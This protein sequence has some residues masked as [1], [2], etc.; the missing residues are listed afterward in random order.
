[1]RTGELISG[2]SVWTGWGFEANS[3]GALSLFVIVTLAPKPT[4]VV[5]GETPCA[6][7]VIEPPEAMVPP[8]VGS[9]GEDDLLHDARSAAS[10]RTPRIGVPFERTRIRFMDR[11]SAL[12]TSNEG[13]SR[14]VEGV[15]CSWSRDASFK[16]NAR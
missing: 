13:A 14:E 1:M 8:I 2:Q 11:T 5:F 7:N 3:C 15:W 10:A 16:E 12:R 4:V 9:V 6:V